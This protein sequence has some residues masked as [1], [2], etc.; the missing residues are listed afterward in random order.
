MPFYDPYSGIE[1]ETEEDRKK[2]EEAAKKADNTVAT[3][4]KVTTYENGSQT[5]ETKKEIPPNE[6]SFFSNLGN[7]IGQAGTNFVNNVQQAPTNFANNLQ[8]GFT[9]LQNAPQNFVNNVQAMGSTPAVFRPGMEGQ[10]QQPVLTPNTQVQQMPVGPVAPSA[11][12][13]RMLQVESGNRDYTTTGQPVTSPKGAM[14]ASQVMPATAA[15]PGFGVRPAQSQTPEEY[16]RVGREYYQA[17]LNQFNG[18]EQ[19]AAAAYNAGPGRV[20][21]NLAQNQGQLNVSQL[22]TE[23]QNYLQKIKAMAP[24]QQAMP[25]PQPQP[26]EQYSLAQG[27][28]PGMGL[29]I[30]QQM[31]Q[32]QAQPNTMDFINQ[33]Q[34][35]QDNPQDLLKLGFSDTTP[36]WLRNR[37]KARAGEI[38][39]SETKQREAQQQLA[40]LNQNDMARLLTK[41][42]EGNSVGDWLQYLLFKHVGL[43]DLAD[44]KGAQLG[45]GKTMVTTGDD[46]TPYMIKVSNNGTPLEGINGV[47]GKT[48]SQKEL[49]T[50]ASGAGSKLNIVGGSYINDKTG[51]VGRL[52]TDEK[53]GR[54]YIQTDTGRKPMT[55]FRPQSSQGSLGDMRARLLQEATV[56]AVGKTWDEAQQILRPYNQ[57]L[58]GQGLPIIQASEL[59]LKGPDYGGGQPASAAAPAAPAQPSPVA[60]TS[61]Q[62]SISGGP[63]VKPAVPGQA[64]TARPTLGQ[65][66]AQKTQQK[67]AAQEI[68]IDLGKATANQ[69]KLEQNA[70]FLITKIDDLFS[71]EKAF[72]DSVG[73]KGMGL[74]VGLKETPIAGTKEADWMSKFGVVKGQ[75]F[76]TAIENLRGMGALSNIEGDT[77]TKAI[78]EMSQSQSEEQ[79]KK[80]A[81]EFQ[82]VI[83]RGVDRVRDKLGQPLKYGT[84]PAS[85]QAKEQAKE[86]AKP[87]SAEDRKALEWVRNNPDDPRAKEVKKRLGL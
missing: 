60:P 36:E 58:A 26:S 35:I 64:P 22:P 6:Q 7:A 69:G 47:T 12:Y 86:K 50:A 11:N 71:D 24:Q 8:R 40:N 78:M 2:R 37:A 29:Q 84:P 10:F 68:G 9:N 19:K 21:Q 15:Q 65:I 25:Q 18:D 55:G 1:I 43:N 34:Q 49:I 70:D 3:E 39:D 52:V 32:P 77:A 31:A 27:M 62:P 73:F 83:R 53:T 51:E 4:H 56:K 41:K 61:T 23:T 54:S 57:A 67:E 17:L 33:Y 87:L 13:Q 81:K 46:G 74:L 75:A 14:F 28:R 30:P 79:F 5:V 38:L 66:E 16:N 20:Q 45:I 85:E 48:L 82:D 76:L 44:Q 80:S 72:R 59:G 63:P 42:S